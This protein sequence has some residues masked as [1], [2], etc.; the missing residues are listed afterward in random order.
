MCKYLPEEVIVSAVITAA[1]T[2]F[3]G[4]GITKDVIVTLSG[5]FVAIIVLLFNLTPENSPT[6]K[7]VR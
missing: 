6:S 3:Y 2:S 7:V 4:G 5:A 1:W